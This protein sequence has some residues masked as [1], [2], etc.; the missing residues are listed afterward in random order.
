MQE[1]ALDQLRE[2]A[3]AWHKEGQ[4]WHFHVLSPKCTFNTN[5]QYS[6]VLENPG[7]NQHYVAYSSHLVA[8]LP[9]ELA[10][11]LHGAKVLDPDQEV[12]EPSG[13]IKDMTQLAQQLTTLGVEWHHHML[14]PECTLNRHKPN[15]VIVMEDPRTD[16]VHESVTEYDPTNELKGIE[17]LYHQN[18]EMRQSQ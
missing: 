16:E 11:L 6:Y 1:V 15:Y 8:S 3:L 9:K 18:N 10:P 17:M 13:R 14:F 7:A 4:D 5:G 12:P 2:Q